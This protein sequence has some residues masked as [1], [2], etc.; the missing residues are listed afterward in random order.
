MIDY[1]ANQGQ[2]LIEVP[3]MSEKK[4]ENPTVKIASVIG[5]I[6]FVIVLMLAMFAK[7][8]LPIVGWIVI[9]LAVMGVALGIASKNKE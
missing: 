9:P 4:S 8:Q 6:I 5:G 3:R 7:D 1:C 2:C